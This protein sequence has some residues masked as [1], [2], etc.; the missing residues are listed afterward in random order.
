MHSLIDSILVSIV[1]INIYKIKMSYKIVVEYYEIITSILLVSNEILK[2]LKFCKVI[3]VIRFVTSLIGRQPA[4]S[5]SY[6]AA[7]L[8]LHLMRVLWLSWI[9]AL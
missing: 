1:S 2:T 6:T 3:V 4:S 9:Q 7:F 8:F 5:I